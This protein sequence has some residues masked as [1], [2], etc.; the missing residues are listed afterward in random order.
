MWWFARSGEAIPRQVAHIPF[1]P[2]SLL[3]AAT[4]YSGSGGCAVGNTQG[5]DNRHSG[6]GSGSPYWIARIN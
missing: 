4:R 3:G 6:T 1:L 5:P 2:D